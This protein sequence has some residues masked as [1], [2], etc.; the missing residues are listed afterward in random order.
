[1]FI[2]NLDKRELY[3]ACNKEIADKLQTVY[4]IPLLSIMDGIYYFK[5]TNELQSAISELGIKEE[6]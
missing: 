4:K 2:K 3:F 5:K 6:V 1:M